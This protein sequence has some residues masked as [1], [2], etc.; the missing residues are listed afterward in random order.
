MAMKAKTL[1]ADD[2]DYEAAKV[3]AAAFGENINA[4]FQRFVREYPSWV[5]SRCT[6]TTRCGQDDGHKGRCVTV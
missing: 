4:A 5:A 3:A 2:A 6:R 1:R